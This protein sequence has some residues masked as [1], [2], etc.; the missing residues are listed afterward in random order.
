MALMVTLG[1]V[2]S[3]LASD[4][5]TLDYD[6]VAIFSDSLNHASIID[7]IHLAQ[8]QHRVE[9]FV[10]R[11]CDMTHLDSLLWVLHFISSQPQCFYSNIMSFAHL[12]V[13]HCSVDRSNCK[14]RKKVVV[15]DR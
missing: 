9:V 11:H 8:R 4:S 1:Y 5:K 14:M 3:I 15:T 6:R 13:I 7:G 12:L 2:G 10:Y